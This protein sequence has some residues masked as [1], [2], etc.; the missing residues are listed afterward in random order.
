MS[1][2]LIPLLVDVPMW[3]QGV[4][5]LKVWAKEN[6]GNDGQKSDIN[7]EIGSQVPSLHHPLQEQFS[8]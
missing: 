5:Q 4:G 3:K 7:R 8:L 6:M 1:T 2:P